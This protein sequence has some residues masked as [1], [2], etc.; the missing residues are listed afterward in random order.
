MHA[1]NLLHYPDWASQRRRW[2]RRWTSSAGVVAGLIVAWWFTGWVQEASRQ[3]SHEHSVLQ[4]QLTQHQ[5]QREKHQKMQV[6]Q[7]KWLAQSAHLAHLEQ[8]HRTWL[9]LYQAL[10]RVTG[11]DAI[12]LLR[13][14]LEANNLEIQGRAR[15]VDGMDAA[16][17]AL[18]ATLA[19]HLSP[20]L[21]VSSWLV[22]PNMGRA[23]SVT[24]QGGVQVVSQPVRLDKGLEFVWQSGWP[25][26]SVLAQ[27]KSA[28]PAGTSDEQEQ[29]PRQGQ[30]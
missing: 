1:F 15:D 26:A 4:L 25:D 18:S 27:I 24:V 13:L 19:Q 23:N 11:P 14:Q 3:V 9:T 29:E 8:Q 5:Q 7:K 28:E 20:V 12:E 22:K 2:H 6:Q 30:P 16:H 21:H 17:Q 10:Q